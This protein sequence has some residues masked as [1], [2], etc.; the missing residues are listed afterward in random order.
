MLT[1]PSGNSTAS[2]FLNQEP[3]TSAREKWHGLS[4]A[5]KIAIGTTVGAVAL[6]AAAGLL[7]YFLRQRRIGAR[8]ASLAER[9]AEAERVEMEQFEHKGFDPDGYSARGGGELVG[10]QQQPPPLQH[11]RDDHRGSSRGG[12]TMT[13]ADS[14]HV[15][16]TTVASPLAASPWGGSVASTGPLAASASAASVASASTAARRGNRVASPAPSSHRRESS[17]ALGFDFGV[18]PLSPDKPAQQPSRAPSPMAAAGRVRASTP[19]SRSQSPGLPP[20]GPL[21]SP[22]SQMR[23]NPAS[24]MGSPAPAIHS[25][26]GPAAPGRSISD[27]R[28]GPHGRP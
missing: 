24:R 5:S 23:I 2:T 13:D 28:P 12:A 21:P 17:N 16:E 27:G 9:R 6:L 10:L 19:L 11:G 20:S 4:P 15:P 8:E 14:Y 26:L 18:A 7:F 25:P 1:N 3:E 22:R